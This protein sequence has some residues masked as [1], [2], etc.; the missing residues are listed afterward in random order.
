MKQLFLICLLLSIGGVSPAQPFRF[1]FLT[2][3]HIGGSATAEEDLRQ[4]VERINRTDS[5]S[6]VIVAGDITENGDR[7]SL[8]T[9]K[10]LLDQLRIP[11]YITSGNHDTKWSESGATD[12]PLIYGSDYFRFE[13]H[14][15]LFVGFNTGPVI[16]IADGHVAPQDIRALSRDLKKWGKKKPVVVIT[17]YPLQ[18][19]DVDNWYEATG[20]L[21]KYNVRAVLGGH[22]HSDRLCFYDGIPAFI[23]RS[24]L[25]G[26]EPCGG[27]TVFEVTA[28]SI[29]ACRQMTCTAELQKRGG[30]SLHAAYY[31]LDESSYERPDYSVNQQYL[32][33]SEVWRNRLGAAIY[34]SPAVKDGYVY[35]GDDMGVFHCLNMKDGKTKWR[36]RSGRRIVGMAAVADGKVV[37][38]STDK[39]IYCLDA[40][41]GRLLW[42]TAA[43][44]AVLGAAA[45]SGNVVY[46]GASDHAFRAIDLSTG[47]M[48]WTCT[49]INGYIETCPLIYGDRVIFGAWDNQLYALRKSDG[50]LLWKW[51]GGLTRMHYSPAAV[52][53]VATDGKVFIT[54]PDRAMTAIDVHTG[55]TVWRTKQSTVR[56]TIGLSGDSLRVF[57]KTM[58][59]SI[60]CFSAIGSS[61]KKQWA[62]FV[63][64]GYEFA[65]SMPQ[66]KDGVIFGSTM[67]GEIFAVESVSGQLLWRHKVSHSLINTVFPVSRRQCVYAC[68]D[69]TVALLNSR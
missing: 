56:E 25:R 61:V 4:S 68:T 35:I 7:E 2:D 34:A 41:T 40:F 21:R 19:G 47:Q 13:S 23:N 6:F 30:Y 60:V 15:F 16:R 5:L 37:F 53:P 44:E 54:A 17:H 29:R 20:L 9:A 39:N 36:Y 33:T 45:I 65:P 49:G 42:K 48:L 32:G 43:E 38:G 46:I 58:N 67:N 52:W 8:K 64:Y 10:R 69:G 26:K 51:N 12:F 14:G 31:G 63:G 57:S 50:T 3:L 55:Q 62:T 24:T 11:W 59:D 28:D 27:Y 1:A 22:Y 66:E 18:K